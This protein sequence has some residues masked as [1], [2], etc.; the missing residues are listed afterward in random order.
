MPHRSGDDVRNVVLNEMNQPFAAYA[1]DADAMAAWDGLIAARDAVNAVLETARA[2]KKIG[3]SLEAKVTI[4]AARLT[5]ARQVSM[6]E[7]ADL[8]IVS[9][10]EVSGEADEIRVEPAAGVKCPRCWKVTGQADAEGLCPRCAAV[11]AKL[12]QF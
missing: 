9:Q 8:L 12:P 1:L 11:V 10:A 3:K 2:E 7:L 5:G 4:P 6:E